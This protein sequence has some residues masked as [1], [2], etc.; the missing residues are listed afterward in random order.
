PGTGGS[1]THEPS[2]SDHARPDPSG[3]GRASASPPAAT[4]PRRTFTS[5]PPSPRVQSA[6][7]VNRATTS[8]PSGVRVSVRTNRSGTNAQSPGTNTPPLISSVP[9][10]ITSSS[11]HRY[12]P[13]PGRDQPGGNA[14]ADA[15]PGSRQTRT[16][17]VPS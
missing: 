15:A 4:R 6:R 1:V 14:T 2:C 9:S 10:T 3:D 12:Q 17:V 7:L 13:G 16:G 5:A 11:P 8:A